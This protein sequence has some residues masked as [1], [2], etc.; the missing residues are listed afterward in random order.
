MCVLIIISSQSGDEPSRQG[1]VLGAHAC[2]KPLRRLCASVRACCRDRSW[3]Q[4][5]HGPSSGSELIVEALIWG[6]S[7]GTLLLTRTPKATSIT[8]QP[9]V[10]LK[11]LPI[12]HYCL[13]IQSREREPSE[14]N[15]RSSRPTWYSSLCNVKSCNCLVKDYIVMWVFVTRENRSVRSVVD[16]GS[17]GWV[18]LH[19]G[20]LR[21]T[22]HASF[23]N[24]RD[25]QENAAFS[26][27]APGENF[28]VNMMRPLLCVLV[29]FKV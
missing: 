24:K 14:E 25:L 12:R 17:I 28:F 18:G 16:R 11:L 22:S 3:S 21:G 15:D 4:N 9:G 5:W 6:L 20:L 1:Q 2:R 23:H 8:A 7:F 27:K 10:K 13:I 29:H 26:V 19:R